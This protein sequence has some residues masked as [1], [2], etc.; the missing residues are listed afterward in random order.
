MEERKVEISVQN[1]NF[2]I[3]K[4]NQNYKY[5]EYVYF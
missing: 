3:N 1:Y 5:L 2:Y 4:T